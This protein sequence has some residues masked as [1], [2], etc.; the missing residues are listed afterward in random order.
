MD[1]ILFYSRFSPH[2]QA[3]IAQFTNITDK[4]VCVDSSQSRAHLAELGVV[5]VPTL[6]VVS[7]DEIIQRVVGADSIRVWLMMTVYHADTLVGPAGAPAAPDAEP[8]AAPAVTVVEIDDLLPP[9]EE[10]PISQKE[11]VNVKQVAEE[12]QRARDRFIDDTKNSHLKGTI[13]NE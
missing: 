1:Y 11:S 13:P 6:L 2:S 5:S 12:L 9:P 4:A 10:Y 8:V 3:L 7:G